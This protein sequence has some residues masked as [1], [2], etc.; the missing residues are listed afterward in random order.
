MGVKWDDK[1]LAQN[2]DTRAILMQGFA[3]QGLTSH[4]NFLSEGN[5]ISKNN[6]KKDESVL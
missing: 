3:E 2:V 1:C 4:N 6:G 5:F